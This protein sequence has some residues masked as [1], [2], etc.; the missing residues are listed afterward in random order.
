MNNNSTTDKQISAL[1]G[2]GAIIVFFVV[3]WSGEFAA[4]LEMLELAYG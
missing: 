1:I 3:Y 2:A 4:M